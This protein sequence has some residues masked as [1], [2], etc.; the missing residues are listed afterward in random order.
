MSSARCPLGC[1]ALPRAPSRAL[2]R[3]RESARLVGDVRMGAR[4]RIHEEPA[5][6]PCCRCNKV[7]KPLFFLIIPDISPVMLSASSE[8]NDK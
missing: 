3:R 4:V 5:M 7:H 6:H 8:S 1:A 2:H